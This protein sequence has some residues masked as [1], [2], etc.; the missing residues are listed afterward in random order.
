MRLDKA[1][2]LGGESKECLIRHA[3]RQGFL[4]E[5]LTFLGNRG[6]ILSIEEMNEP[7]SN[8]SSILS[9]LPPREIIEIME[10]EIWL[11]RGEMLRGIRRS[12]GSLSDEYQERFNAVLA[13]SAA[14][15]TK[16]ARRAINVAPC[17][18]GPL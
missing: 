16:Q 14:F 2:L 9:S 12:Y 15:E 10:N 8:G 18:G 17:Y 4:N 5:M 1:F 11:G 3:A 7:D 6:E 13:L